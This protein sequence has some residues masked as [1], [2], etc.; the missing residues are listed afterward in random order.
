[1]LGVS[2]D[3]RTQETLRETLGKRAAEATL[4]SAAIRVRRGDPAEQIAAE[5]REA[6]YDFV[7]AGAGEVESLKGRRGSPGLVEELAART[8][9]PLLAAR[10]RP[11]QLRDAS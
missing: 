9:I 2:P 6:P 11:R 10:G 3:A 8:K 4:A 5:T 1:M 7:I